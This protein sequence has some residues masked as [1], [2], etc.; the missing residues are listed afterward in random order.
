MRFQGGGKFS[1]KGCGVYIEDQNHKMKAGLVGTYSGI[2]Q[3][4]WVLV[5]LALSQ[6]RK[7]KALLE[8][9]CVCLDSPVPPQE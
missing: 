9:G 1:D 7:R 3:K 6:P 4:C 8:P 5:E 2:V